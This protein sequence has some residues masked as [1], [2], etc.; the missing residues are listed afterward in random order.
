VNLTNHIVTCY[1]RSQ[2]IQRF[3][4]RQQLRKH[5]DDAR[6][7]KG[8]VT[9][10]AVTSGSRIG[11]ASL[12]P[13][14]KGSDIS[15]PCLESSPDLWVI[16]PLARRYKDCAFWLFFRLQYVSERSTYHVV[17]RGPDLLRY[18]LHKLIRNVA[19]YLNINV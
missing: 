6:V 19:R 11:R 13:K 17:V 2:P 10:P 7:G 4:A 14:S 15:C 12:D 16:E 8:H 3:I 9:A 18:R 1:L 5:L